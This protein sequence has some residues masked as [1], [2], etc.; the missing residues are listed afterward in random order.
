MKTFS[1]RAVS[2]AVGATAESTLQ[3]VDKLLREHGL[4][5]IMVNTDREALVMVES[6]ITETVVMET[7][8]TNTLDLSQKKKFQQNRIPG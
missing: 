5:V 7:P 2:L 8:P 1:S 3:V 4:E 6:I